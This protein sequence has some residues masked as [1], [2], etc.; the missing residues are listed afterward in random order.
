LLDADALT[1]PDKALW[2]AL[3]QKRRELADA[4]GVPPYV[5]FSDATLADM[6][7]RRP[8]SLG[9]MMDVSGVGEFKLSHYGET[10]LEVIR[11]HPTSTI[12][13]RTQA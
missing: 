8:S 11:A 5:I 6:L 9:E 2:E 4:R 12:D 10:F 13:E 7:S 3:R 1:A